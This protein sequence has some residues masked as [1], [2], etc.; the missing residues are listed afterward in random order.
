MPALQRHR[1]TEA[2]HPPARLSGGGTA[3]GGRSPRRR[4][5]AAVRCASGCRR[6]RRGTG[7]RSARDRATRC[8]RG[9]CRAISPSDQ[10]AYRPK[11]RTLPD[12]RPGGV[13]AA[14]SPSGACI[15]ASYPPPYDDR[16]EVQSRETSSGGR[17]GVGGG[18]AAPPARP[19]H[20]TARVAGRSVPR[21]MP[22]PVARSRRRVR[23]SPRRRRIGA[24]PRARR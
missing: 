5:T 23:G 18:P 7:A 14:P 16:P 2:G 19:A 15:D 10:P 11:L 8:T 22:R 1:P 12:G 17:G 20:R 3:R 24:A 13:P 9:P 21:P 6:S 4:R